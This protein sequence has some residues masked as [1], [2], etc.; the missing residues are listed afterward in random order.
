MLNVSDISEFIYCPAK[1]YLKYAEDANIYNKEFIGGKIVHEAWKGL[2][3]I[4]RYNI[5]NVNKNMEIA[6]IQKIMLNK[7]PEY[8]EKLQN[9][10]YPYFDSEKDS[11]KFFNE[12][13]EDFIIE[14]SINTLKIKKLLETTKKQEI[15]IGEILFPQSLID[16]PIQNEELNLK[17]RID[18]IEIINGV[19]YPVL[20]K[21]TF[22]PSK[23]TWLSDALQIAVYSLLIEYELN[24]EVLVGFIYYTKIFERRQVVVNSD[25][26]NK[27]YNALNCIK[28]MFEKEEIPEFKTSKNK[29]KK[30]VYIDICACSKN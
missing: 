4:Q 14:S 15:E 1:L 2:E 28:G 24:K 9:K 6:E 16:F 20:I 23:G 11:N 8:I 22:P 17:G 5:W 27:L 13:Q 10:Y 29:C 7:V 30:C 26:L 3:N 21:N 25:L 19:Y 12:L 18:K